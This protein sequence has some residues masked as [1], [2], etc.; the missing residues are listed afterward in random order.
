MTQRITKHTG[1]KGKT[2]NPKRKKK[3]LVVQGGGEG[4]TGNIPPQIKDFSQF[5]P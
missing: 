4:Q 2:K 3:N 5:F 1:I